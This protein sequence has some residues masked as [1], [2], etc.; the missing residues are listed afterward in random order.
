MTNKYRITI[1]LW[2]NLWIITAFYWDKKNFVLEKYQRVFYSQHSSQRDCIRD[3]R[4]EKREERETDVWFPEFSVTPGLRGVEM[5]VLT[6][7]SG[8]VRTPSS[9]LGLPPGLPWAHVN[10]HEGHGIIYREWLKRYRNTGVRFY[11]DVLHCGPNQ[12]WIA[13]G[14]RWLLAARLST[15]SHSSRFIPRLSGCPGA[16]PGSWWKLFQSRGRCQSL[17]LKAIRHPGEPGHSRRLHYVTAATRRHGPGPVCYSLFQQFIHDF[18]SLCLAKLQPKQLRREIATWV[19][20]WTLIAKKYLQAALSH[21]VTLLRFNS[22]IANIRRS[23][24]LLRLKQKMPQMEISKRVPRRNSCNLKCEMNNDSMF[25]ER[26]ILAIWMIPCNKPWVLPEDVYCEFESFLL[27]IFCFEQ[28]IQGPRKRQ[29][30][31][32]SPDSDWVPSVES[33]SLPAA[34]SFKAF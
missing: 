9:V 16:S 18:F 20:F 31:I 8:T 12:T 33:S 22:Q 11:T 13:Q 24:I 7:M 34:S 10:K 1:A 30:G 21:H 32:P 5:C 28:K 2:N 26:S 19:K 3:L 6:Q 4:I 14:M 23:Q 27:F 15:F 29:T 17:S 25:Y